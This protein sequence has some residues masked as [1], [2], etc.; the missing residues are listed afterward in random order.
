LKGSMDG[1]EDM[2]ATAKPARRGSD[3]KFRA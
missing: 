1:M 2:A 3:C